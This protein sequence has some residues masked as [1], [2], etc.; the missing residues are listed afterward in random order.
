MT[1]VW[2]VQEQNVCVVCFV[3][4]QN[5]C[6]V[7]FVQEQNVYAAFIT[8]RERTTLR[9]AETTLEVALLKQVESSSVYT[10]L[11]GNAFSTK[12]FASA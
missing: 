9:I 5:V 1:I 6:V 8:A 10:V 4:E 12:S 7:C 3:Q 11:M 2:F